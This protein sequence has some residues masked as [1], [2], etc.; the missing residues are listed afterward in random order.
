VSQKTLKAIAVAVQAGVPTVTWGGPGVGKT[1]GINALGKAL[2]RPVETVIASLREPSDFGGLPILTESGVKLSPPAWAVRLSEAGNGILFVDEIST[3]A[4]AVQAA[5]LRVCLSEEREG[6]QVNMVGE[7]AIKGLAIVAA[8]NPP[9]Q[10][11]GGWEMSPPLSNR[12]CH[13]TWNLNVGEYVQ[14]MFEG[15]PAPSFPILP[16][17][18]NEGIRQARV[19]IASFIQHKQTLLYACPKNDS[20]AGK[21]WPSPRSWTMAATLSAAAKA[22]NAG[23]EVELPLISGCVGEGPALEFI[24]WRDSLDLPNPEELLANPDSFVVPDRGDKVYTILASV[25]SAA[26]SDMTK[27]RFLAAWQIFKMAADAGKKDLA[28]A[29]VR[30]LAKA[31][32]QQGY[33]ADAKVRTQVVAYLV[34]FVEILKQAGLY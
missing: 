28:A 8:A 14:G 16:A 3:A 11:A 4:P 6:E 24:N 22:S 18:W 32:T 12:F 30:T 31:A 23:P 20:D 17:N 9:D 5:L 19:E 1:S 10:A 34:P 29:A 26:V 21:P 25:A 15:F 2:N 13:L 33:M 7:L 27:A